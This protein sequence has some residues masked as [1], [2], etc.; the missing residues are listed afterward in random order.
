MIFHL[1]NAYHRLLTK[2]ADLLTLT[3]EDTAFEGYF[4]LA[5]LLFL[6]I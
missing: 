6:D 4:Q 5:L 3:D 2:V 1:E